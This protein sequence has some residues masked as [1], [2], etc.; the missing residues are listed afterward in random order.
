M[1][2]AGRA[3]VTADTL[4][5]A[6]SVSKPVAAVAALRLVQEGRIGLDTDVNAA[7]KSW[8]IASNAYTAARPVTL[9]DPWAATRAGAEEIGGRYCEHCHVSRVVPDGSDATR[10]LALGCG[11]L[12]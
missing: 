7:L 8:K 6:G 9:R 12:K 11:D 10:P 2:G 1:T 5:Q 4:F 3:A